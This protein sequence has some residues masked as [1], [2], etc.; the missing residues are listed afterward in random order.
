MDQ[1]L[2]ADHVIDYTHED[3][4]RGSQRYDVI[5][6]NVGSHSALDYRHVL[7]PKGTLVIVGGTNDGPWLGAMA[8][9]LGTMFVSPFVSQR[10]GFF[11]AK[12]NHDDLDYLRSLLQDGKIKPVIDRRYKL[13]EAAEAIKYLEGGHA[14]GKVVINLEGD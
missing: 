7:E 3:F 10:M 4:T 2:G 14:R 1:S 13:A 6:D 8:G 12:L 11:L 9:T 5:V